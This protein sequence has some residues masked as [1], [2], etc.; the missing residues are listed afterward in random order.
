MARDLG[1][2]QRL[3]QAGPLTWLLAL[4]CGWALLVWLGAL[5]GMG[6][7]LGVTTPGALE[8]LPAPGAAVRDRM[9]P[10]GQYAD[11]ASRPLFTQDRRPHP[12]LATGPGEDGAAEAN[13]ALDF[14]LTGV[15]LSPALQMAIL[16]PSAGG[17]SQRVRVGSSP[18]GAAGWRLVELQPRR[19]IFEGAG[20]QM[21]LDL[22][23]FGTDGKQMAAGAAAQA[24][25]AAAASADA[26][27]PPMP[28][29]T[30]DEQRRIEDIRRRIEARRAQMQA[31]GGSAPT[32]APSSPG[33]RNLNANGSAVRRPQSKPAN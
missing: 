28:P 16:Q 12:F 26:A 14:V 23:T 33:N 3:Q 11:A 2:L 19:A 17:D 5:L 22:R 24:A 7:R 1:G 18:E 31:Q 9:G 8:P 20:G 32:A 13:A 21:T 10:L 15:V 30:P 4:A 6:G 29:P 25:D 27:L